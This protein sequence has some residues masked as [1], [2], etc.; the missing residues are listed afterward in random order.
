MDVDIEWLAVISHLTH[1]VPQV[2]FLLPENKAFIC[3]QLRLIFLFS[4]RTRG[5]CGGGSNL[6]RSAGF[7][8]QVV[9]VSTVLQHVDMPA[10]A[11]AP[12][13]C[14]LEFLAK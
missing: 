7:S 1:N 2:I 10:E 4:T 14:F 5:G 13:R 9:G 11:S 12:S 6:A 8:R 3:V